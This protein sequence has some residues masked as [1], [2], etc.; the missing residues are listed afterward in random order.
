MGNNDSPQLSIFSGEPEKNNE[1][2]DSLDQMDTEISVVRVKYTSNERTT[3]EEIFG[4]YNEIRVITYSYGLSFIEEVMK[5]FD[6]GEVLVGFDKII[7]R[8]LATLISMQDYTFDYVSKNTY[9]QSC[10]SEEKLKFFVLNDLISHQ[11]VYLL[12]ADDGRV[13]TITGSANFSERAWTNKQLENFTVCDD[14]GS[15]EYYEKHYETLKS[16]SSKDLSIDALPISDDFE[17][18]ANLPIMKTIEQNHAVILNVARSEAEQDY[19]VRYN[20]F[21]KKWEELLEPVKLK[22][23][24]DGTILFDVKKANTLLDA[25]KKTE[26][27]KQERLPINPQF[28]LNF[29]EKTATYNHNQFDL[30]P[31]MISIKNNF[32][33]LIDYMKGFELFTKDTHRLKKLYWKVLNYMFLSPFIPKLRYE[34]DRYGY[35]DRFF[36]MYMLIYGDSDAGKTGFINLVQQMMFNTIIPPMPQENFSK[37]PMASLKVD[38]KGYPILIDELTPT[39]WKYA[40][41]IV[42]MDTLLIKKKNINHPSFVLLSNDI[43]NV[44]PELSK[45]I[46]V[47]NLDNRLNRT[48]AA[49]KG[50]EINAIRKSVNNSL[51]REYLRRMF[52]KVEN[53]IHEMQINDI[54]NNDSWIPDIFKISSQIL[55]DIM[56]DC[57]IERP[58]EFKIFSWFDYMGDAVIGEKALNMIKDEFTHNTKIFIINSAKNELVI[59][60]SCYAENE[61]TK[62]I[63]ILYDELPANV[64][65]RKVGNKAILRLDSIKAHTN[66]N[67]KKKWWKRE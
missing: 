22:K 58:N 31:D 48:V 15:Y 38:I 59:D 33:K 14:I 8:E 64:E 44:A 6:Y 18:I 4:G 9:L 39:Y 16:F 67:F 61:A 25:V 63:K 66:L 55:L 41:D 12:K 1:T 57:E 54:E 56:H 11:K 34:G 27:R 60:F 19:A 7:N 45:R 17:N 65:C 2:Y 40:K 10:I 21:E 36:P 3:Y 35:E 24:N 28:E 42:K 37:K 32:S 51:Y 30:N 26:Q 29:T 52:N 23:E 50:K 49:F 53:L 13:R 47:I 5:Y 46:I 62:K 43:N 20:K